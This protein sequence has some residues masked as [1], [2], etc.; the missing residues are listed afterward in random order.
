MLYLRTY[1]KQDAEEIVGWIKDEVAFRKWSADR[2]D[3]YPVCPEDINRQYQGYETSDTFFPMTACDEHGVVGHLIMRFP[4]EDRKVLRFGFIIVDTAKRSMGYG[5]QML[6]LAV[7]Y[8]FETYDVEKITLGV[9]EN[10]PAAYHCY[11]AVGFRDVQLEKTEY[12]HVM[13][14]DWKCMEMELE[15]K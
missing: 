9:F 3:S 5:K 7:H 14:Q 11:R 2:Y 4:G 15:R 6:A 1:E 10:N 8:A 12:Y 13:G